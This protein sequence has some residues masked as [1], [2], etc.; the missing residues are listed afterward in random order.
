MRTRIATVVLLSACIA[1]PLGARAQTVGLGPPGISVDQARDIAVMNGV[2]A[3][4]KIELYDGNWKVEGRDEAGRHVE[5]QIDPR[6]GA[7][8]H[9]ERYD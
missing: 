6:T 1:A 2:I 9:L 8:A 5:M 3:I 4:R 7:I